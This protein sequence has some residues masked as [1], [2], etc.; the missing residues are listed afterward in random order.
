MELLEHFGSYHRRID[1]YVSVARNPKLIAQ[2]N[3]GPFELST[4]KE[5]GQCGYKTSKGQARLTEHQVVHM[6]RDLLKKLP[7]RQPY[8]CPACFYESSTRISLVRHFCQH[9]RNRSIRGEE[10]EI[11]ENFEEDDEAGDGT[12]LTMLQV[13]ASYGV[14]QTQKLQTGQKSCVK[15]TKSKSLRE[16]I[17]I[18]LS[19]ENSEEEEEDEEVEDHSVDAQ[20][21]RWCKEVPGII[22]GLTNQQTNS[23]RQREPGLSTLSS[24]RVAT[25]QE[26]KL[27]A[28]N[29]PHAWLCEGRLLQL[30]DAIDPGNLPLFQQQ[31][32][33]GQP[34]LISNSNERMNHRLWHP[35][36]FAKDF[37]HIRSDLVNTLTGKTVPRQPLKWFWEGFENVSHRLLN[38]QGTPMLL[39]L[40]D[41]PPDGDIAE[42]MPKRFHDLVHDFPIQQYTLREGSV[43]LA[44]Y[45]PDFYLR[46]ELG[47]KMYIAYG[48]AL[49]S[50]KASTNLHLDMSDA[51]NL[52]VYVGIPGDSEKQENIKLVLSQ[53]DEAGCDII[54]RRRVRDEGQLPGAIWHIYHPG[55]T[56]KIRDLLN[57]VAIEKGRRL[58]PHDD[59]IHDQSTYLDAGLRMR[60]YAE[61]GVKGY[62]IIQCQGDTVFIPC[63]ACHQ[64]RNLHNCIKIAEDFVSPELANNCLHL[65]QVDMRGYFNHSLVI[66]FLFRSSVI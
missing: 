7:N 26:S 48:N 43:N 33:R 9:H 4:K 30:Q 28:P 59:P 5:C 62:A 52:M 66:S 6:M 57:R 25:M 20:L 29:T 19:S 47:P 14:H 31:W 36:A 63:G 16:S 21:A 37:G 61:Y 54:M 10:V 45:I 1:F 35:R 39:K 46:P 64:V 24:R 51:V 3:S 8:I 65:T 23:N 56:N 44:S 58:D 13:C 53:I 15:P 11:E 32:D 18:L 55:D 40:K 38:A 49:Y 50:N 41:W 22:P 27:M 12:K 34:V 17:E 42:Y 2:M 60:L